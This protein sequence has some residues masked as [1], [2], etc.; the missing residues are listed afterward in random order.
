MTTEKEYFKYLNNLRD[1]VVVRTCS[2]LEITLDGRT[3]SLQR[4][5][6]QDLS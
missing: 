6:L 2:E 4:N 3:L 5:N 1:Q